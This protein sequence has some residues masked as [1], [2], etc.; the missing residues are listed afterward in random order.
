MMTV[1]EALAPLRRRG[2]LAITAFLWANVL[3]IAPVGLVTGA[4]DVWI[5]LAL[6]LLASA[7]PSWCWYRGRIDGEAR[8]SAALALLLC[9]MLFVFLF[10]GHPW[11][12]DLHMYFFVCFSLLVPLC[13]G[14]AILAAAAV[15]LVHHLAFYLLLPGWVF[16][17]SGSLARVLLHGTLVGCEVVILLTAV[18]MIRT[19]TASNQA[20]RDE[21]ERDRE[22]AERARRAA[23]EARAGAEQALS[24]SRAAEAR[25]EREHAERLSA[26]AALQT[27]SGQRRHEAADRIEQSIGLLV[28][29]L[30]SVSRGIARQAQDITAV[31]TILTD[32]AHGL[33]AAS[34][35]AATAMKD[36]ARRSGEMTGAIRSVGSNAEVARQVAQEA[37][38]SIATLAPG[39]ERLSAEVD[40]ARDILSMVS[41]IASQSNLL[42]LNATIEAARSGEAGRGFA[43]VAAEMKQMAAATGRAAAEITTKLAAIV[44]A[45]SAFRV[46]IATSAGHADA[47]RS[48]SVAIFGAVAQQQQATDAIAD[49]A[50]QVLG[51]AVDTETRSHTLN[52][53]AQTNGSIACDAALLARQLGERAEQ[54]RGGM[55]GLL[56]ELRAA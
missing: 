47:I 49:G 6:A 28:E 46:L 9:P 3:V 37:A 29:D 31:S 32:Q 38:E 2:L 36:V 18:R 34:A 22:L 13:D 25:A 43:V 52:E 7:V 14:R 39:I 26:E 5:V 4:A 24:L 54:L 8:M 42:A 17:G 20:A 1:D 35:G 30:L 40:A 11:Q 16:P 27:L 33:S 45:A 21:A 12:M 44:Q 50:E 23:D 55:N 53:V 56:A 10:R 51:R 15:T 41:Q 48:S 19:L